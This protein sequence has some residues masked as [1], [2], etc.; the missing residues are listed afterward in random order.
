[1]AKVKGQNLRI[2]MDN[3]SGGMSAVAA[4]KKCDLSVRTTVM[5]TST[6]DDEK[7]FDNIVVVTLSWTVRAS[8]VVTVDEYRNDPS[9]LLDRIGESVRVQLALT[10]GKK[11][12]EVD[13]VVL[14]GEAILSDVS[15]TAANHEESVFD[16]L[17][18]GKKNLLFPMAFLCS[19][20]PL[21]LVTSD[22]K[23]LTVFDDR[24]PEQREQNG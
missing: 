22:D 20:E 15:I 2:F 8:G 3:G 16:V 19:S 13:E 10:K 12:S 4:S 11:N 14:I 1:M 17:L 5:S 9:T 21:M 24:T 23:M 6:K 7:G 18:T